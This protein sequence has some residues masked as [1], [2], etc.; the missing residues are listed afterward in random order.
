M[1]LHICVEFQQRVE[2]HG[3]CCSDVDAEH[4][5]LLDVARGSRPA[6]G[7]AARGLRA[8]ALTGTATG[9]SPSL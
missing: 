4:I 8:E 2:R 7:Y 9:A 3:Q 1:F 6:G 5:V